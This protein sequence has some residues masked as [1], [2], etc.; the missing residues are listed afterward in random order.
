MKQHISKEEAVDLTNDL[1][2]LDDLMI[3]IFLTAVGTTQINYSADYLKVEAY[4]NFG[5]NWAVFLVIAGL[6]FLKPKYR[7]VGKVLQLEL[8]S[9]RLIISQFNP[10]V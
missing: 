7:Q 1:D 3:Y 8:L 5:L 6:F 9:L 10:I 4:A 2:S